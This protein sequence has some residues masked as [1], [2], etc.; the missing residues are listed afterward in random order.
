MHALRARSVNLSSP[1]VALSMTAAVLIVILSVIGAAASRPLVG[2]AYA[3]SNL[4]LGLVS[5]VVF[6][7]VA[8]Q[9]SE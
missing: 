4:V 3:I 8:F 7:S 9:N 5:G 6:L 2:D 1:S